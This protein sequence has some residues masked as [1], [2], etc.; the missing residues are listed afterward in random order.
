MSAILIRF[1][2]TRDG[3]NLLR[4]AVTL[5]PSIA[6]YLATTIDWDEDAVEMRRMGLPIASNPR[7]EVR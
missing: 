7:R 5:S 1:P 2:R 4:E 3:R 6:E